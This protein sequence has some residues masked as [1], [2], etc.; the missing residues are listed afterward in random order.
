MSA[1]RCIVIGLPVVK[2]FSTLAGPLETVAQALNLR[3]GL[4]KPTVFPVDGCRNKLGDQL[5]QG[6]SGNRLA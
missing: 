3:I 4:T 5:A 2:E 1:T 6:A